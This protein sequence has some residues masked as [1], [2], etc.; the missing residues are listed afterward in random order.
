M[1]GCHVEFEEVTEDG[2]FVQE[3]LLSGEH[4]SFKLEFPTIPGCAGD[5]TVVGVNNVEW[6]GVGGC[7]DGS[8]FGGGAGGFL[9]ESDHGAA[10]V[11]MC[12]LVRFIPVGLVELLKVGRGSE[13][14]CNVE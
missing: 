13:G 12:V 5:D 4:P 7:V 6:S 1:H 2:P 3:A 10:V 14:V 11:M 8:T 9:G